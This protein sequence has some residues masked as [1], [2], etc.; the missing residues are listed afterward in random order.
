MTALQ[1]QMLREAMDK[2]MTDEEA[3]GLI[4]DMGTLIA[5]LAKIAK[6]KDQFEMVR[7]AI[8]IGNL[9]DYATRRFA[10]AILARRDA[11]Q[12]REGGSNE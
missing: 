9:A 2:Q 3:I 1:R 6:P 10:L 12:T 8:R 5:C 4:V 7:K 11:P